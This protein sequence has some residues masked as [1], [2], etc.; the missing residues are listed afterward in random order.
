M[1]NG[2]IYLFCAVICVIILGFIW[3]FYRKK[4]QYK[5]AGS[6]NLVVHDAHAV[7]VT[8]SNPLPAIEEQ[9]QTAIPDIAVSPQKPFK[10]RE[11]AICKTDILDG[12]KWTKKQGIYYHKK[13]WKA[14]EKL[15]ME[16]ERNEDD[17]R[18]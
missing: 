11:C 1:S 15:I 4:K 5:K 10:I 16:G 7:E 18:T 9:E 2:I 8:G 12:H 17:L 13:C 3:Y 6:N 14:A